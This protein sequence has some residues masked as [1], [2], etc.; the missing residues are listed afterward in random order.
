MKKHLYF[1]LL[2][3][4]LAIGLVFVG[5]GDD[6][7]GSGPNVNPGR[8]LVGMSF[9]GIDDAGRPIEVRIF[10]ASTNG[11]VYEPANQDEFTI[12]FEGQ[13]ISRGRITI[14]DSNVTFWPNSGGSFTG[15]LIGMF[16]D[17]PSIP[18]NGS[19]ITGFSTQSGGF[20]GAGPGAARILFP[21]EVAPGNV[22]GS[23][24]S[25]GSGNPAGA[26]PTHIT[27]AFEEEV[28][29]NPRSVQIITPWLGRAALHPKYYTGPETLITAGTVAPTFAPFAADKSY[30]ISLELDPASIKFGAVNA[31]IIQRDFDATPQHLVIYGDAVT[32]VASTTI[33]GWSGGTTVATTT[34]GALDSA[35]IVFAGISGIT[36]PLTAANIVQLPDEDNKGEF[37]I[38]PGNPFEPNPALVGTDYVLKIEPKTE[39]AARFFINHPAVDPVILGLGGSQITK[40]A[41]ATLAAAEEALR[42]ITT[43]TDTSITLGANDTLGNTAVQANAIVISLTRRVPNGAGG[44]VTDTDYDGEQTVTIRGIGSTGQELHGRDIFGWV[45]PMTAAASAAAATPIN[46]DR[47]LL[48]LEQYISGNR[49]DVEFEDGVARIA[50][51]FAKAG[52]HEITFDVDGLR[53]TLNIA[54]SRLTVGPLTDVKIVRQ[55]SRGEIGAANA[56]TLYPLPAVRLFDLFGNRIESGSPR[57]FTV[58]LAPGSGALTTVPSS[59]ANWNLDPINLL[60]E[61]ASGAGYANATAVNNVSLIF[62]TGGEPSD[63]TTPFNV[64]IP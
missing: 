64:I 15:R 62:T 49:V 2:A 32:T 45:V 9:V 42:V 58:A 52:A 26:A 38:L 17:I 48:T 60:W 57:S 37:T 33:Q 6:N 50:I 14:D 51:A 28:S 8:N 41:P 40:R 47:V 25:G 36:P 7:G 10:R 22:V 35:R 20:I 63:P 3:V 18:Y 19:T 13:E 30:V 44:L 34:R 56:I 43:I 54:A 12:T 55:I 46:A 27:F 21:W 31:S 1:G 11:A 59:A 29:L 53:T 39:G 61:P 16:L 23:A 24:W 4:L 5:C